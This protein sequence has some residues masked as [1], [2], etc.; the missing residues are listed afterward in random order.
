MLPSQEES[1]RV[2]K[3]V[4]PN[5]TEE[6]RWNEVYMVLFPGASAESLPTPCKLPSHTRSPLL[7]STHITHDPPQ[8][9]C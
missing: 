9:R 8:W 3:R 5:T 1:L 2:K 6:Q 7:C 4:P